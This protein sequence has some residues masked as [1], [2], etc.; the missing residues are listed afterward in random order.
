MLVLDA[1]IHQYSI[2]QFNLFQIL[3]MVPKKNLMTNRLYKQKC[4]GLTVCG[5]QTILKILSKFVNGSD[6][7]S[8]KTQTQTV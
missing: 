7:E 4:I 1:L 3:R 8:Q 2:L 5:T 6:I